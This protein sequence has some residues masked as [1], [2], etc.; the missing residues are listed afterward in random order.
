MV[1]VF[2]PWCF[3]RTRVTSTICLLRGTHVHKHNCTHQV[4]SKHHRRRL[5]NVFS[6]ATD[7][8]FLKQMN[9]INSLWQVWLFFFQPAAAFVL[10]SDGPKSANG[11]RQIDGIPRFHTSTPLFP[12]RNPPR[13]RHNKHYRWNNEHMSDL[14]KS[15]LRACPY[16]RR[17]PNPK[18]CTAP[19]DCISAQTFPSRTGTSCLHKLT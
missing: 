10:T 15:K 17:P 16:Q 5:S 2:I 3:I 4:C 13:H 18:R 6:C 14:R 12:C 8:R 7:R 19:T 9:I 11:T 1:L